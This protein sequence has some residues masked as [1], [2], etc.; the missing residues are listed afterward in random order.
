MYSGHELWR[1]LEAATELANSGPPVWHDDHLAEPGQLQAFLDRH[2]IP[3]PQAPRQE[4]VA[5]AHQLRAQLREVFAAADEHT[6]V[7]C[8]NALVDHA[9]LRPQLEPDQHAWRWQATPPADARLDSYL[10]ARVGVALLSL[11]TTD[12]LNRLHGCAAEGCHGVFVDTT[13]NRSRRYCLPELCG[14]RTNLAAYRARR[15]ARTEE[16]L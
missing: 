13:R 4:D 3:V 2:D 6:A 14:N 7:A 9:D 5:A 10:V 16:S 15:R 8:L 11:I 1:A 12:G